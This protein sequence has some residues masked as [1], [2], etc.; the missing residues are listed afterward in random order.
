[1]NRAYLVLATTLL[2]SAPGAALAQPGRGGDSSGMAD[3]FFWN[4]GP[5]PGRPFG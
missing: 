5:E 3:R 2:L 1:M 4:D